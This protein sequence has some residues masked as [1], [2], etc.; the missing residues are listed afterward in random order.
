M[1]IIINQRPIILHI[2]H[3]KMRFSIKIFFLFLLCNGFFTTK[4]L[5]QGKLK[6]NSSSAV[7]TKD[8]AYLAAE[9]GLTTVDMGLYQGSLLLQGMSEL[10]VQ[11]NDPKLLQTT[12][13]YFEK[14]K[15]KE[16]DVRGSFLS[17]KA[18]GSGAA[19]LYYF[20]KSDAVKAQVL[21]RASEM[22][23]NQKRT[24]EGILT[25]PW[26]KDSLDQVMI[27][28]AFAVTPYLL[29]TGLAE[30]RQDYI[31]LAVFQTLELFKILRDKNGLL[32]QARGFQA[33]GKI[34][35]DNWSRGNGWGALA[36]AILI[37]DL[38][39]EHPKKVEINA[40]GK[41]FY[42][43][44][45]KFQNQ[46]GLWNQEMSQ[47]TSYVETSGSGLMLYALG[48]AIEK[49]II[50]KSNIVKLEKGLS[51]YLS[52]ID[53]EGNVSHTCIGCLCP[54]NGTKKD[55]IN[56]R[57]K[58]NDAHAFG[59]VVLAFTQ[60]NRLGIKK[61]KPYK[62]LGSFADRDSISRKPQTYVRFMPEANG[63]IIWEN[64]RIAYRVYGSPAAAKVSSGIDVWTKSVPYPITDNWYEMNSMGKEYHIDRGE[65]CDFFHVGFSRGNGGTAIWANEKPY[66]SKP[67][68]SH[69]ILKNTETEIAFELLFEPWDVDGV[70]VYEKK[71]ISM[72]MGTNFFK[73][74]STFYA[75]G[76]KTLTVALGIAAAKKPEVFT[77][78]KKGSLTI[79]ESYLPQNGELGTSIVLKSKKTKAFA[80]YKNEHFILTDVK[81]GKKITY[82]VGAGWTKSQEFKSQQEWLYY[83]NEQ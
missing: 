7:K 73:V 14:I 16:I 55:Y 13:S 4:G 44:I 32:H 76:K 46:E 50:D 23:K 77:D 8:V 42:E 34:C 65:G 39:N 10:A 20:K 11:Q 81:V 15:K 6:A 12:L 17:Y 31:D 28:V 24:S 75:E 35:E 66:I 63:N 38:P 37:R 45:L 47:A 60:A 36:L 70:K 51:G 25:A 49:N 61:V 54:E 43:A 3:I 58:L 40:L 68:K 30:K 62:S 79:W 29:Y 52:Y 5:A 72:K 80:T 67:Y 27:D 33:K 82:F 2:R 59:P 64:D 1:T 9:K 71:I 83:V 57:W 78:A 74:E 22:F 26:L 48:I 69:R 21:E 41:N 56:R 19:Y 53:A 18:G